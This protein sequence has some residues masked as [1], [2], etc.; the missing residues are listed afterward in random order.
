[1]KRPSAHLHGVTQARA[2][3]LDPRRASG[4]HIPLRRIDSR[5]R[6]H[7]MRSAYDARDPRR[8]ARILAHD[9][10]TARARFQRDSGD[11][12]YVARR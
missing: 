6:G 10:K 1:M 11:V 8:S 12:G 5:A 3:H 7:G 9:V 2:S 4:R